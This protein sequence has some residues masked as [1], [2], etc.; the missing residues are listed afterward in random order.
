MGPCPETSGHLKAPA[1]WPTGRRPRC[2]GFAG[3]NDR[4]RHPTRRRSDG[5]AG[6]GRQADR[7]SFSGEARNGSDLNHP[8]PF[9][10]SRQPAVAVERV[11][12][13]RR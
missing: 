4:P 1:E 12:V 9:P 3:A 13:E 5:V 8:S 6:I 11:K 2:S 7:I 10:D